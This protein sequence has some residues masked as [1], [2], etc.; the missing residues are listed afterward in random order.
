MVSQG[1][2]SFFSGY[3]FEVPEV[4]A[5]PDDPNTRRMKAL[6]PFLLCPWSAGIVG[7]VHYI[8]DRL[9]GNPTVP[10]VEEE[11]GAGADAVATT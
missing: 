6:L 11:E 5:V 8:L 7:L 1:I 2:Q 3:P 10:V 4:P 9:A